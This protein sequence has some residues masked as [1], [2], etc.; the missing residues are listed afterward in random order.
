MLKEHS[1]YLQT[2]NLKIFC[3]QNENEHIS[4]T[5]S[6]NLPSKRRRWT[7]LEKSANQN[8]SAKEELVAEK[9][10]HHS[11]PQEEL[12]KRKATIR[13][14]GSELV[15]AKEKVNELSMSLS[16]KI[17][18]L[19]QM[20]SKLKQA[21]ETIASL[22]SSIEKERDMASFLTEKL[23]ESAIELSKQKEETKQTRSSSR[24]TGSQP[25]SS[26]L[27]LIEAAMVHFKAGVA[28]LEDAKVCDI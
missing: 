14:L 16:L 5:A 13:E 20:G 25:N 18:E 12:E 21:T 8:T 9:Q 2:N 22:E 24:G 15:G 4:S 23:K 19:A 27:K 6:I 10:A 28:S 26:V 1:S 11:D 17:E 7:F 3:I